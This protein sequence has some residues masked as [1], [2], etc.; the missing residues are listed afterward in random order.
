MLAIVALLTT[1]MLVAR[2]GGESSEDA[3]PRRLGPAMIGAPVDVGASPVSIAVGAGAVWVVDA[4]RGTLIRVD[5][6]TREVSGRS[7]RVAGGPFSV[8][9]GEGAVWVASGDGSVRAFDPRTVRPTGRAA[10]VRGANGL[11]VGAGGVWVTSRLAGTVTR[12]D[13]RTRR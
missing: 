3:P 13:P 11:A 1:V 7:A 10:R 6:R 4:A 9:V 12:I 5:P 8:A 2:P